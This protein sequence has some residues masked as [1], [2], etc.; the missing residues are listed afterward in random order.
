MKTY[1]EIVE[2]V[3]DESN[4]V[5]LIAALKEEIGH[6]D[7]PIAAIH[8]VELVALSDMN[9]WL[10]SLLITVIDDSVIDGVA[11]SVSLAL[12]AHSLVKDVFRLRAMLALKHQAVEKK[13]V[14]PK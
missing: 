5:D 13:L 6:M 14:V 12:K 3:G 11:E 2:E 7:L 4:L 9:E 10:I 8:Q 1:E